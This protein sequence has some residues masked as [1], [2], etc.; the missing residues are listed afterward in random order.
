MTTAGSALA[1]FPFLFGETQTH[2]LCKAETP[3]TEQHHFVLQLHVLLLQLLQVL[4][5]P[6]VCIHHLALRTHTHIKYVE[7]QKIYVSS[8][9]AH[10]D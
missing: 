2:L 4:S 7:F 3:S 8:R 10:T 9:M 6:I 1:N 5:A